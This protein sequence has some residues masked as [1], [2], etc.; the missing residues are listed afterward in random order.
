MPDSDY[1]IALLLDQVCDKFEAD[2]D[3]AEDLDFNPYL[4]LV[5]DN[6]RDRLLYLLIDI[7]VDLCIE[8]GIEFST[9]RYVEF[10]E[11]AS[12]YAMAKLSKLNS[13]AARHPNGN[14]LVATKQIDSDPILEHAGKTIGPFRLLKELGRG[15]MGTVWL[16]EQQE[17]VKRRVALKLLRPEISSKEFF[18]RFKAERQ[19]LAMM[20]HPNIAKVFDAGTSIDGIPYFAMELIEGTRVTQFCDDNDLSIQERLEVFLDIC[21]AVQHAHQKGIIHRDLKPSNVLVSSVD[22]VPT[23]KVIDFGLAKAVEQSK[24]LIEET[25]LTE[26]GRVLGTIKYMAPEQ[27]ELGARDVDTRSDIYSLGVILYEL[28]AGSTPIEDELV[29]QLDL[30]SLLEMIRK[31]DPPKPSD[32]FR[33]I[34][35][36]DTSIS[37]KRKLSA[38]RLRKVLQGELDS[39]VMKALEKQQNR[40]FVSAA[41]FADDINRY[42]KGEIVISRPPS[43]SYRIQ[44]FIYIHRAFLASLFAVMLVLCLGAV[45]TILG[46]AFGLYQS[47]S[48]QMEAQEALAGEKKARIEAEDARAFAVEQQN[49][50][51]QE[52]VKAIV[53]ESLAKEE[54]ERAKNAEADAE[55]AK[56]VAQLSAKNEA[57]FKARAIEES[58]LAKKLS[59]EAILQ[60][61]IARWDAN[62]IA[63][64]RKILESVPVEYW[65][66]FE[67]RYCRRHFE[68]SDFTALGHINSVFCVDFSHDGAQIVSGSADSTIK[69]WDS[70]TG[71]EIA[72][73]LGH[74]KIVYDV[75]FSP[76]GKK[77]VS[78]GQ[79]GL[80]LLWDSH[81]GEKLASFV[82]HTGGVTC[83][84][85]NSDGTLIV[86][87]SDDRTIK[88]WDT[89]SS[90][91]VVTI[92]GHKGPVQCVAFSPD[93]KTIASTG[94]DGFIRLWNSSE[95][96]AADSTFKADNS[97][98]RRVVFSPD[99]MFILSGGR[100][101]SL[102][103]REVAN[104]NKLLSINGHDSSVSSIDYCP[105][106]TRFASTSSSGVVK[107]WDA[108]T[109]KNHDSF[110]GHVGLVTGVSFSPD[111]S[112]IVTGGIDCSVRVWDAKSGQKLITLYDHSDKV[113]CVKFDVSGRRFASASFDNTVLLWDADTSIR[114]ATLRGHKRGVNCVAFSRDGQYLLTGSKD[115]TIKLWSTDSGQE[116]QAIGGFDEEIEEVAFSSDGKQFFSLTSASVLQLWD[117]QSRQLIRTF[118]PRKIFGPIECMALSSDGRRIAAGIAGNL[119]IWNVD[120]G[121]LLVDLNTDQVGHS[122]VSVAFNSDGSQVVTGSFNSDIAIWDAESGE[123]LRSM[124]G[125][126]G[127]VTCVAFNSRGDRVLS[128]SWDHSIKIWD[129]ESGKEVFTPARHDDRVNAVAFS[130]DDSMIV[131]ASWDET[132]KLSRTQSG[133]NLTLRGPT[134]FVRDA[135]FSP[136]GDKVVAVAWDQRIKIWNVATGK[137]LV[138]IN[139]PQSVA[140][141]QFSQDGNRVYTRGEGIT[142][143]WDADSGDLI[144][145]KIEFENDLDK[146][147]S[148]DGKWMVLP[149]NENVIVVDLEFQKS[150]SELA[151]RKKKASTDEFWHLKQAKESLNQNNNYSATFHYAWLVK[152]KPE[153]ENYSEM[154]LKQYERL[155]TEFEKKGKS[156]EST[157]TRVVKEAF[158]ST[159]KPKT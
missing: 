8:S 50:S 18:I 12:S 144:G 4:E 9:I 106:G 92:D 133:K 6:L 40:R 128:G 13:L 121:E 158:E 57:V 45:G 99:G 85:F 15:G 123:E 35:I 3:A 81:T 118:Q 82:G 107:I 61:A 29:R 117:L 87:G 67:N 90:D 138:S 43:T 74:E 86:S 114:L 104:G 46:I 110:K 21:S 33:S 125:H 115:K 49:I 159:K 127:A 91:E 34:E 132:L 17:P 39:I 98:A 65:D 14:Q 44:K 71:Q 154:F 28:L 141:V 54:A 140:N 32:R 31:N 48:Y 101:G 109:G 150:E 20:D 47:I 37:E 116:L 148:R 84:S 10:G 113:S 142:Y 156:F 130:P 22:G 60:L 24:R 69:I 135:A 30:F 157:N 53:A 62:R 19:A 26:F 38:E 131:S 63:D 96:W 151:Y 94:I 51:E 97:G 79:D 77:I 100:D 36:S 58:K 112:R 55:K 7:D 120:S 153:N 95:N 129:S 88:I 139:P 134:S 52:K 75:K 93:S 102:T 41:E 152:L 147:S 143:S 83:V 136:N 122:V 73:L 155:K 149:S 105:D 56:L 111:G 76:D 80:V 42:L 2:W 126:S 23:P 64:A 70:V 103:V 145:E 89:A 59:A 16:A 1:S 146:R 78:A 11:A 72:S 5:T 25:N 124:K 68:G 119:R 27:A 108:N 66:K 137:Q